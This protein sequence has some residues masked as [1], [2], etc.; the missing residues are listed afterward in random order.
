MKTVNLPDGRGLPVM[1]LGT[2]R[3]GE[4]RSDKMAEVRV[5]QK[6]LDLGISLLDTAEIYGDGGSERI[7]GEAIRGRRDSAFIVSKV[8]PSHA[9]RK[10]TIGACEASLSRLGIETLDLYLLHWRGGVPPSETAE[11]FETLKSQGKIRAWGVSNFDVDDLE[12]IRN[13]AG[14]SANQVLY[15]PQS[16]GI[17]YNLLPL[18]QSHH[19]PI[20]AYTPFGQNGVVLKNAAIAGVAR[21]HNATPGQ[22][23]LAWGIRH[24]GVVTIPKTATLTRVEENLGALSLQL[25]ADDLAEIDRAFPPP[26]R[27][28]S[29]EML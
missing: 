9:S 5:I 21:R 28:S 3:M 23:T 14:C 18:C 19:I 15:N 13:L 20:M 27:K 10:G 8:A 1:G 4:A 22:V 2:W 6:A 12:D 25:T 29:L 24:P 16:R 26:R 17:E 7:V 11:A